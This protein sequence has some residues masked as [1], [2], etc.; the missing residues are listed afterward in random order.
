MAEN[1]F[2]SQSKDEN[3]FKSSEQCQI[4]NSELVFSENKCNQASE[5]RS[6]QVKEKS[7]GQSSGKDKLPTVTTRS[8]RNIK[9]PEHLQDFECD[10]LFTEMY[11]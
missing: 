8:G 2:K 11:V 10:S 4:E 1:I 6:E 7:K 3:V 9:R 5:D